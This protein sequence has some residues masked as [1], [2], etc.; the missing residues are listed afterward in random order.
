MTASATKN[1]QDEISMQSAPNPQMYNSAPPYYHY[2]SPGL[3][4]DSF[5]INDDERVVFSAL[6]GVWGILRRTSKNRIDGS[7]PALWCDFF[8]GLRQSF[9]KCSDKQQ[10]PVGRS[11][12]FQESSTQVTESGQNSTVPFK[13]QC[14]NNKSIWRVRWRQKLCSPEA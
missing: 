3:G 14:G 4:D 5:D 7:K 2:S 10:R 11:I 13:E 9:S 1:A 8:D 6:H 12:E